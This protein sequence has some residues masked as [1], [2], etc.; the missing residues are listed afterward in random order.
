MLLRY[1]HSMKI[2]LVNGGAPLKIRGAIHSS[3]NADNIELK[4]A[5]VISAL[6]IQMEFHTNCWGFTSSSNGYFHN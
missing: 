3:R 1:S 2:L 5:Y 4:V 6:V